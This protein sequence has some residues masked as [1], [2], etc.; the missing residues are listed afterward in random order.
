MSTLGNSTFQNINEPYQEL[1]SKIPCYDKLE[2][3]FPSLVNRVTP[4]TP[5][6][7]DL[8]FFKYKYENGDIYE[9]H[10]RISD[11]LEIPPS[12]EQDGADWIKTNI[13]KQWICPS[14]KATPR[15]PMESLDLLQRGEV[16]KKF[17][18]IDCCFKHSV[19]VMK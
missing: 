13:K 12:P 8:Y 16:A 15:H 3:G 10:W 7:P 19:G 1:L 6:E 9:G 4:T 2:N 18:F 5:G 11:T 14:G 17:P